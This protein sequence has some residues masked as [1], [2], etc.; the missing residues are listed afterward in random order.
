MWTRRS[1]YEWCSCSLKWFENILPIS[2]SEE[3]VSKLVIVSFLD[4][5][6]RT[7]HCCDMTTERNFRVFTSMHIMYKITRVLYGDTS[8][9]VVTSCGSCCV[10]C[11]PVVS[12]R[13]RKIPHIQHQ[14]MN[15]GTS[16]SRIMSFDLTENCLPVLPLLLDFTTGIPHCTCSCVYH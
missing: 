12:L 5:T 6:W 3:G 11:W 7:M 14:R 15:T 2:L 16:R 10:F 8:H 1:I 9:R 13:R 4:V